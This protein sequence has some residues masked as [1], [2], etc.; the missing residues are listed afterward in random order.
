MAYNTALKVRS[1]KNGGAESQNVTDYL[2]SLTWSGNY[3]DCC[4]ELSGDLLRGATCEMGGQMRMYHAADVLFSGRC[5]EREGDSRERA[6]SFTAYDHGIYL[7]RNST[8]LAVRKRTP[9]AVTRQIC[10]QYGVTVGKLAV[11]GCRLSRNFL[12]V[13]LYQI[14]QT[15]Y[16]LASKQTG[17][18]YQ[19]RFS[20]D[21]LNVVTKEINAESLLLIPGNN[22]LRCSSRD[23]ITDMVNSVAVYNDNF[24]RTAT[25]KSDKNYIALYGLMEKAIKAS[26]DESPQ[27]TAK[28]LLEE[29]GVQTTI[30]ADCIGNLKLISGNT[31]VVKEPVTGTNGLFWILTDS[32]TLA[33]GIH[34]TKVTLDFRNLMDEEDA[35]SLPTK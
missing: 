30:S 21:A 28:E 32:H 9:E 17:K 25:Y 29:N 19:I 10:Q 35:G 20:G 12:G 27:K 3:R 34:Q 2:Q 5:F 33:K 14:I 13:S 16:T 26:S 6:I 8:Y 18:K 1:W 31:V 4:R 22:L 11:T 24:R 23:S 15:M 7:K